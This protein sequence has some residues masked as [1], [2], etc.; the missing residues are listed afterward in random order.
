MRIG[1]VSIGIVP[2]FPQTDY[3]HINSGSRIAGVSDDYLTV[4]IYK[5]NLRR[6]LGFF[7]RAMISAAS[8][9]TYGS[10]TQR[11]SYA[12]KAADRRL[13]ALGKNSRIVTFLLLRFLPADR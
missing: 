7:H 5:S 13:T 2:L 11:S 12:A 10:T 8:Y 9:E 4:A 1:V 3:G 6:S